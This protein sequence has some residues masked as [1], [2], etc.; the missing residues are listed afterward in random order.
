MG[1]KKRTRLM[2]YKGIDQLNRVVEIANLP[3]R[4]VS[5]VPSQTELLVDLGLEDRIVGVTRYCVH[6]ENLRTDKV[7]VGGTKKIVL[8]RIYELQPDLIIANK[9]ENTLDIVAACDQ[10]APTYVSDILTLEN[11]YEM[12]HDIGMM[13]GSSFKAKS[14]VRTIKME[15]NKLKVNSAKNAVYLIWK[16]PYMATGNDTFIH[17]VLRQGGFE[18]LCK[19][20][21]RYP[22]FSLDELIKLQPEFI[23]LSSEPY[24]FKEEDKQELIEAFTLAPAS[25]ALKPKVIPKIVLVDGEMFSWYGSRLKLVPE[26]LSKLQDQLN[27]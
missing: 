13:T 2:F 9:E 26:Y 6:P 10:I 1:N 8:E 15:F 14:L 16:N 21:Q 18:N 24:P 22:E 4:I 5:L 20:L 3:E 19:D 17:H 12:I 25:D 27:N 23:L 7:V 11:A